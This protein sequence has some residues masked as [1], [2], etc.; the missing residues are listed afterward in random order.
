MGDSAWTISGAAEAV[1]LHPSTLT[2]RFGLLWCALPTAVSAAEQI[3]HN[4]ESRLAETLPNLDDITIGTAT[5]DHEQ[6]ANSL[7]H[8]DD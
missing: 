1:G 3:V 2:K 8:D 4:A 5:T 7:D 6:R